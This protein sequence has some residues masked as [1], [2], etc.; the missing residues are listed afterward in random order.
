MEK[1]F[2]IEFEKKF[3][4]KPSLLKKNKQQTQPTLI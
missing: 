1:K 3:E 4:F 2:R